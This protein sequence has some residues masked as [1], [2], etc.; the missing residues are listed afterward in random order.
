MKKCLSCHAA[1]DAPA[2]VCPKC[3]W[4]PQ[5]HENIVQFAPD[6]AQEND[7]FEQH[8]F[9]RLFSAESR[10]FWFRVRNKIIV[11][12]MQHHFPH[13]KN[14]MEVGCGTGFV[15][16]GIQRSFPT[17]RLCGTEIYTAGLGHAAQRLENKADFFQMD[18]TNIPFQ[19]E[20]DCVG[21]FDC[22]EHIEQDELALSQ[23]YQALKSGG[24]VIFTV[25]QHPALWSE[26]DVRA[27]HKRRYRRGELEGKMITAGFNI[28]DT[29]S[30]VSFLLPAMFL[31]RVLKPVDKKDKTQA[32]HSIDGLHLPAFINNL[33]YA[34]LRLELFLIRLGV[35]FPIGGSRLVVGVRQ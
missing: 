4:Q 19:D 23:I 32:G 27:C 18:G 26:D 22:L 10:N 2:W 3:A 34:V 15:L 30:F 35:R 8:S 28:V 1:F 24:H 21:A 6:L 13:M 25:P 33:F 9:E 11:W 16:A 17:A 31:D 20:F 29:T 12:F 14:F 5:V 7:G